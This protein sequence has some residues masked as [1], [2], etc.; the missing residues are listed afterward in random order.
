MKNLFAG[1]TFI[2][3]AF[4]FCSVHVAAQDNPPKIMNGG[5][6]NG[7][8][9]TLPKPAYPAEAREAKAEGT[10]SVRITIDEAGNVISAEA[11]WEDLRKSVEEGTAVSTE[12]KTIH[13]AL[14]EAAENA[15]RE[16][17]F[18]PTTLSG[19]PVKVTGR[20][21]YNFVAG[22]RETENYNLVDGDRETENDGKKI[23]GGVLNGKARS[24]PK[25]VYPSA[26]AAIGAEGAISV[27]I[28]VDEEGNVVSA[29]AVSGHPLLR[30]AAVAAARE[31]KFAPTM[32]SG[33]LVK[34]S[35]VLTYNFV[36]PKREDQ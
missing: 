1:L 12:Y 5:V 14:R 15:A 21:V 25:P 13:P 28:V 26:A 34:V 24:L 11:D 8:A 4:I 29:R 17:K 35:G 23:S 22:D 30:A 20:I 10:F 18:S 2:F 36:A 27:A 3:F 33:E 6:L 7:K 9:I 19:Q 16:A 31:A 32:L